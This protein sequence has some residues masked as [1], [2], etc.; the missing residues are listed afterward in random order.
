MLEIIIYNALFFAIPL[1]FIVLFGISLFRY[2]SAK[3][4]NRATP[5]KFSDKQIKTRGIILIVLSVI[6]GIFVAVV[7]GFVGLMYMAVAYM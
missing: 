4:Q 7:L 1:L 5:G 2:I 3:R 6:L